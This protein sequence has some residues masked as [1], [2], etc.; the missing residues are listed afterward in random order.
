MAAQVQASRAM[1]TL[2][3]DLSYAF[4]LLS[5]NP[6]FALA[7]VLVFAL[8]I[9]LN[10]AVFTLLNAVLLR[11]LSY[12]QPDRLV[13]LLHEGVFP[14][15]PADYLD[16]Q[17]QSHAFDGMGAAQAWGANLSGGGR[18]EAVPGLRMTSSL[19]QEIGRAHV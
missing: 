15:S 3:Q 10:V 14:V 5:K 16:Y 7:T 18:P 2:R 12:V 1:D 9:G 8:G 17:R 6:V 4:R 11:P 19:F 13:V